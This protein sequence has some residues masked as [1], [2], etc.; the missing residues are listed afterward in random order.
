MAQQTLTVHTDFLP[1]SAQ[2]SFHVSCKVGDV[3]IVEK[4]YVHGWMTANKGVPCFVLEEEVYKYC[5][6][7]T[8]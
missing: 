8:L 3:L 2:K 6:P 7:K 5:T 4:E 1:V